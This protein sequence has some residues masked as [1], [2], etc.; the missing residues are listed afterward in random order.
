MRNSKRGL[1]AAS[2]L[3][4]PAC[5]KSKLE[6]CNAFVDR[7]TQ[8]QNVVNGLKLDSEN[9]VELEKGASAIEAEAKAFSALELKDEKLVGY[10][11]A[12]AG[13]LEQLAKI[14]HDL[15]ALQKDSKDPAKADSLE[16]ETKKID[17]EAD[18]V[19]KSESDVVDQV[20][21]Y[22]TGSK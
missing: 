12:Y 20:N 2:L 5:G 6:Q 16:A 19:E 4:L 22:C 3:L 7:A 9:V 17:A 13:T 21:Q 14:L 11:A 10:R 15:S 18:K 8:A 1:L